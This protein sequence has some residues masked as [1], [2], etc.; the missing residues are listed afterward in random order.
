MQGKHVKKAAPVFSGVPHLI[1]G[2]DYNPDQWLDWPDILEEDNRLMKLAGGQQ[3]F[4]HSGGRARF[5]YGSVFP[6]A[7]EQGL[8]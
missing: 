3:A 7:E 8:G 5:R 6:V 1:H 2:G 4:R